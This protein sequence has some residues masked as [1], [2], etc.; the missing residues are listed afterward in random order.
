MMRF[1]CL[2]VLAEKNIA[3][4]HRPKLM[5][6]KLRTTIARQNISFLHASPRERTEDYPQGYDEGLFPEAKWRNS[7][8]GG[9]S[10]LLEPKYCTVN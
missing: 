8:G 5:Y 7:R 2:F 6:C 1:F 10:A 3:T 9:G 4:D